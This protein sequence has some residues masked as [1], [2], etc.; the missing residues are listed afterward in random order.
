MPSRGILG[1][2]FR[3]ALKS[4]MPKLFTE[5]ATMRFKRQSKVLGNASRALRWAVLANRPTMNRE[6]TIPTP[7]LLHSLNPKCHIAVLQV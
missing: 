3:G 5:N 7:R 1:S 4:T 6:K 2:L